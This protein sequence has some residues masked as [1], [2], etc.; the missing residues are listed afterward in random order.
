MDLKATSFLIE[1][2]PYPFLHCHSKLVF[3]TLFQGSKVLTVPNLSL[4]LHCKSKLVVYIPFY[5]ASRLLTVPSIMI[6]SLL[7]VRTK[8]VAIAHAEACHSFLILSFSVLLLIH[9]SGLIFT[10]SKGPDTNHAIL[11]LLRISEV[12]FPLFL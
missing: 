5:Q 8:S 7:L 2:L 12:C 1:R 3:Y 11:Q 9:L 10:Y 4:F 6:L